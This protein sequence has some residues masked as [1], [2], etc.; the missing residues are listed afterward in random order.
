MFL[1]ALLLACPPGTDETEWHVVRSRPG[2]PK[3]PT[4][5]VVPTAA[6]L[7]A[8]SAT[9]APASPAVSA[10]APAKL[11]IDGRR[12]LPPAEAEPYPRPTPS[13][14]RIRAIL[15]RPVSL[16]YRDTPLEQVLADARTTFGLPVHVD[17]R[18]LSLANIEPSEPI[19]A[20]F[21]RLPLGTVLDSILEELELAAVVEDGLYKVTDAVATNEN[22]VSLRYPIGDLAANAAEYDDLYESVLETVEPDTWENAGGDGGIT[23]LPSYG[24]ISVRQTHDIHDQIGR[25]LAGLRD[26]ARQRQGIALETPPSPQPAQRLD[27]GQRPPP[28]ARSPAR[29]RFDF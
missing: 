16:D 29:S 24:M 4:H 3:P 9:S 18:G 12:I 20:T 19:T 22:F 17:L 25:L 1:L 13:E 15:A 28:A 5:A 27:T 2:H 26:H 10:T 23:F 11:P 7:P 8:V 14:R 21:D 6:A